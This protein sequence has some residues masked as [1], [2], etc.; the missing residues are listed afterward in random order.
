MK[1]ICSCNRRGEASAGSPAGGL[2]EDL[3]LGLPCEHGKETLVAPDFE[4][5]ERG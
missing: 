4:E 5:V 2:P 1:L 3:R